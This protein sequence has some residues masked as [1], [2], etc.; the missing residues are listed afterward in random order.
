[1]KIKRRVFHYRLSGIFL[2]IGFVISFICFFNGMNLRRLIVNEGKEKRKYHYK[3]ESNLTYYNPYAEYTTL[4]V[5]QA[6][7]G[8]VVLQDVWL[9][10]NNTEETGLTEIICCQN[11]PMNYPVKEGQ[12]P[13]SDEEITIPT[14]ILGIKLKN[15]TKEMNGAYYYTI[16]NRRYRVCAFI[17][18][19]RSDIFDYKVILYGKTMSQ[20]IWE[21]INNQLGASGII[22]S[23]KNSVYSIIDELNTY[24]SEEWSGVQI[25]GST[26]QTESIDSNYMDN[27]IYYYMILLFCCINMILVSEYWIKERYKEI[28]VR[29]MF[30]YTNRNIVVFLYKVLIKYALVAVGV[31]CLV[32]ALLTVFIEEY[33][34]LYFSQIG[35]YLMISTLFI[36]VSCAILM[37]Y[38]LRIMKRDNVMQQILKECS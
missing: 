23:N 35:Y 18:S 21:K 9:Y 30:G 2:I 11:E 26:L 24:A 37:I 5:L 1:M 29:K 10:R 31:A 38:P 12:L 32:Q 19:D 6:D 13:L 3:S 27:S 36:F 25:A 15:E 17:G 22:G 33:L 7:E 4:D 28:A 34:L 14:V 16:E 20:E 8:N